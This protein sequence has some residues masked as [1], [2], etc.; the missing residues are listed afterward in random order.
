MVISIWALSLRGHLL[1][2]KRHLSAF[3]NKIIPCKLILTGIV[4]GSITINQEFR[5]T[6][7]TS[8]VTTELAF[9]IVPDDVLEYDVIIDRNIY[10]DP[11][12]VTITG[13]TGT[14]IVRRRAAQVFRIMPHLQANLENTIDVPEK[15]RLEISNLISRLPKL[16][17]VQFHK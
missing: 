1:I 16:V 10:D 5:A 14:H 15:Y 2:A 3:K 6:L 4:P 17:R 9:H 8:N 7:E 11:E 13:Y 12:I